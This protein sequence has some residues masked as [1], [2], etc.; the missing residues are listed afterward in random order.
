M[1]HYFYLRFSLALV[2]FFFFLLLL[3]EAEREWGEMR[4]GDARPRWDEY[5]KYD[6]NYKRPGFFVIVIV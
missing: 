1:S 6:S 2:F 5:S 3:Y 4:N